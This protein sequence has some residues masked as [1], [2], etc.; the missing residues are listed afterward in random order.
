MSQDEQLKA[1]ADEITEYRKE[2]IERFVGD[3]VA[4]CEQ[5]A[6]EFDPARGRGRG[7]WWANGE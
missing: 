1:I 5:V 3:V 6:I 2:V 4:E 7:P